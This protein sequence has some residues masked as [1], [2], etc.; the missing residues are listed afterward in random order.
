MSNREVKWIEDQLLESYAA[1][2]TTTAALQLAT[3]AVLLHE[4]V[5]GGEQLGHGRYSIT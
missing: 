4:G 3:A 2:V 1:R 5:E